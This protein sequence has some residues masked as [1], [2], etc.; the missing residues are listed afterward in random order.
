MPSPSPLAYWSGI[1]AK[2]LLALEPLGGDQFRA[3]V[4]EANY[5]GAVFG[6]QFLAQALAAASATVPSD[7][8]VHAAHAFFLAPGRLGEELT[9]TVTRL[10]N[11]QS[12]SAR[13]VTALQ[14][15]G[16]LFE[17]VCT[18]ATFREGPAH[19]R[20]A[21]DNIP[22]VDQCQDI[23]DY[24]LAKG[25]AL[26]AFSGE[27]F[28][29]RRPLERRLVDPDAMFLHTGPP[30]RATWLRLSSAAA[31]D[32]PAMLRCLIAYLSDAFLFGVAMAPHV[33][34]GADARIRFASLNHALWLHR[35]PRL[36]DWVL[37]VT[38]S[39]WAGQGRGLGR[40]LLYTR[41]GELIATVAQEGVMLPR[42]GS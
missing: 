29:R 38:E 35:A 15:R 18:F 11:G 6:G 33:V 40:G 39:P 24:I 42:S 8:L 25:P 28:G 14:K 13:R 21:P 22:S 4:A 7:H 5:S 31:I 30:R 16:P 19:S 37:F 20:P 41:S 9:Y 26:P 3:T 12:T 23:V 17:M 34:P 10:R 27:I 2:D 36:D 32:D 1:D